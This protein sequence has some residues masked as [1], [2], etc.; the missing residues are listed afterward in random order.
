LP[1]AFVL[2]WLMG[3]P[4]WKY[5][6][7]RIMGKAIEVLEHRFRALTANQVLSGGLFAFSLIIGTFCVTALILTRIVLDSITLRQVLSLKRF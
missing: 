4:R 7:I 5:H 6:P 2:D 3:D 1:A